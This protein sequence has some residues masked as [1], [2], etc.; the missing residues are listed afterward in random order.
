MDPP[1]A[2][3]KQNCPLSILPTRR[4]FLPWFLTNPSPNS[5]PS[6]VL[7]VISCCY[8]GVCFNN[9]QTMFNR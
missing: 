3:P 4:L 1:Q 8:I 5:N 2:V 7:S 9:F 6:I